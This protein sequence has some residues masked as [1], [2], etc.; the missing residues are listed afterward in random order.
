[1]NLV[2]LLESTKRLAGWRGAGYGQNPDWKLTNALPFAGTKSL[3]FQ[4]QCYGETEKS[5]HI[6]NLQFSGLEYSE[7]PTDK[8]HFQKITYKDEDY[9]M[10][11]PTVTTPVT[12]RCSCSD[13]TYRWAYPDWLKKCL[14]GSK[15]KKYIRKIGSTRPPVNPENI[16]GYC[17]HVFQAQSYLRV[18]GYM[19]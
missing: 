8:D 6:V 5:E 1:M 12:V 11:K 3:L 16:P 9:Y 14:F 13:F 2:E 19:E 7:T 4:L 15:P 10:T 18:H 17:K